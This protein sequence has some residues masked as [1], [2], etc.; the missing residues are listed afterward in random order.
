MSAQ[1][2]SEVAAV[3]TDS[4]RTEDVL[5]IVLELDSRGIDL[6]GSRADRIARQKAGFQEVA[7]PVKAMVL[8]L[9]G[10][11]EAEAWIN[12]AI[13]ARVPAKALIRLSDTQGVL[14]I[15]V[16]HTLSPEG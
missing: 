7:A 12:C 15:D 9:G 16:P 8:E 13:K 14:K 10:S 4:A 3:A 6:N 2:T 5:E 1:M 11:I